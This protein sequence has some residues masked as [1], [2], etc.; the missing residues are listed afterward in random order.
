MSPPPAVNLQIINA[1]AYVSQFP[2][3]LN[4]IS[5]YADFAWFVALTAWCLALLLWWQRPR[6]V[7]LAAWDWLPWSAGF[8]VVMTGIHLAHLVFSRVQASPNGPFLRGDLALGA[9]TA[10]LIA[11]WWWQ[12][13]DRSRH[14]RGL[15]VMLGLLLA[16]CAAWRYDFF[17]ALFP[18]WALTLAG[19]VAALPWL[20]RREANLWSRLAVGAAAL[21]PL[22]STIGPIAYRYFMM[23]RYT[24]LSPAGAWAGCAH[25]L[26]G[27]LALAGLSLALLQRLPQADRSKMRREMRP[28]ALGAAVWLVAALTVAWLVGE[29]QRVRTEERALEQARLAAVLFD[30]AVLAP[31]ADARFRLDHI[32]LARVRNNPIRNGWSDH[33]AT[34]AADAAVRA[35][36]NVAQAT[37]NAIYV[38]F[39][40]LRSGWLGSPINHRTPREGSFR[41]LTRSVGRGEGRVLLL[42]EPTPRDAADWERKAEVVEGP[43]FTPIMG[44]GHVFVRAPLLGV[45]GDML[46]WL[47]FTFTADDFLSETIQSRVAPLT[48]MMLGL[49]VAALFFLQHRRG[50]ERETALRS[51][52]VAAEA[53]RMKTEFLAKVSH[54]LRTPLQSLLGYGELVDR[55]VTDAT[56]RTHLAA[57]RQHGQLMLRL[58]NDL[59]DLSAIEAGAFRLVEQPVNLTAVVREAVESLRPRAETKGLSLDCTMA[60]DIPAWVLGDEQRLRQIILNLA[61]NA[62]KFTPRGGVVVKLSTAGIK[63]GAHGFELGVCDTGPGIAPADQ[64]RLFQPFS[65]LESAAPHEG[66]GLGLALTAALCRS[67]GGTL[68][69][70]SDGRSGTC[71]CATFRAR[72]GDAPRSEGGAPRFDSL[73]GRRVLVADDNRL[74]RELFTAGL[75]DGGAICEQAE[76]GRR[77]LVL[78]SEGNFDAVVLD[79]AMP[80]L[81]GLE[82]AR[83]LR[84]AGR[85]KLRIVG[86]SAH[87]SAADQVRALAAGMD[88]FLGKP[89][90]LAQLAAALSNESIPVSVDHGMHRSAEL[91]KLFR[92]EAPAQMSAVADALER[93]DWPRLVARVHY[94]KNSAGVVGDER[95]YVACGEVEDAAEI[96]GE[97]R[98]VAAWQRCTEELTRWLT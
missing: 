47:E 44:N 56:G 29:R 89:V 57:Q 5:A 37:H 45:A 70:N 31:L 96:Q 38:R 94:L 14:R 3:W 65:R 91:A 53:S 80:E 67:A 43:L 63:E 92:K 13:L 61:G 17:Q 95:L 7:E 32:P 60:E 72:P 24:V 26:A 55:H 10:A 41:R 18:S 76:D 54:E 69:V 51:A 1:G 23:E 71:F 25:A 84:A 11:A 86:V 19:A 16:G 35:L 59:L 83:R 20:F 73:R 77:A 40:T 82:V 33:L 68:T 98:A 79:L 8:S 2:A 22:F 87:A 28:Y 34:G 42:R 50:R 64:A 66:A 90:S 46:G 36:G 21:V 48:G 88:A 9:L 6:T 52:A 39:V 85:D 93:R 15:V 81:D 58:V 97:A 74:V 12:A 4:A 62:V 27:I 78:G 49:V 30:P 75:T